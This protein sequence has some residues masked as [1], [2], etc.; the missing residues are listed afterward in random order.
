MADLVKLISKVHYQ[1]GGVAAVTLGPQNEDKTYAAVIQRADN[2]KWAAAQ[3]WRREALTVT[4][5][6]GRSWLGFAFTIPAPN[7]GARLALQYNGSKAAVSVAPYASWVSQQLWRLAWQDY[8]TGPYAVLGMFDPVHSIFLNLFGGVAQDN[9]PIYAW[10]EDGGNAQVN[11]FWAME[12][13]HWTIDG[14]DTGV[15]E[16]PGVRIPGPIAVVNHVFEAAAADKNYFQLLLSEPASVFDA[17]GYSIPGEYAAEF[18]R[19]YRAHSGVQALHAAIA[20]GRGLDAVP[21]PF[22]T[23]CQIGCL[24]AA[25][26][27]A[28]VGVG[29]IAYLTP[30]AA[31]VI[32][33]AG[34][35]GLTGQ[36]AVAFTASLVAL[37]FG[38]IEAIVLNL[39]QFIGVC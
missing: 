19:F 1:N 4:G 32:A 15:S 28:A 2:S 22:C 29:A 6:D 31:P 37:A 21:S 14:K 34:L 20:A 10:P 7:H 33:V 13:A 17:A 23:S 24:I 25:L 12:P 9:Q 11:E 5:K 27:I 18:N 30:A 35:T 39:C 3:L 26:L 16:A 36:A 8:Q 38:G